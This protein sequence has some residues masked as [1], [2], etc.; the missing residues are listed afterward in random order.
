MSGK[1]S[2][3]VDE[4][5]NLLCQFPGD[6]PVVLLPHYEDGGRRMWRTVNAVQILD[7]DK[8]PVFVGLTT[9]CIGPKEPS[10]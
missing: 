2:L 8:Q 7:A 9:D 4:V 3:T 10:E 1:R 6:T 5:V